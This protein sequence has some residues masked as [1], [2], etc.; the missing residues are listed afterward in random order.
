MNTPKKG[1]WQLAGQIDIEYG[2]ILICD[3][4][5]INNHLKE[6]KEEARKLTYN[7]FLCKPIAP[8]LGVISH[9]GMGEGL[10][11]VEALIAEDEVE[12]GARIVKEIRIRFI[13]NAEDDIS[14]N[15]TSTRKPRTVDMNALRISKMGFGPGNQPKKK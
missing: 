7:D 3:L 10:Y 2:Q 4:G 13:E 12:P 8:N 9:T 1:K 6:L 5:G 11:D 14:I 15:Q